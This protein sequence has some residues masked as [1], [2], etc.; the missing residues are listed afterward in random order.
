MKVQ[1]EYKKIFEAIHKCTTTQSYPFN[2][3]FESSIYL[4]TLN[5][6]NLKSYLEPRPRKPFILGKETFCKSSQ[7]MLQ[8]LASEMWI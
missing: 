3:L 5:D 6:L 2:L 1:N 7:R 4:I 8:N